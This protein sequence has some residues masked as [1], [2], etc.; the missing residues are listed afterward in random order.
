M[1]I[2]GAGIEGDS[3]RVCGCKI[4]LED[5]SERVQKRRGGSLLPCPFHADR[6]P[7]LAMGWGIVR[8]CGRSPR[9]Q[10][11]WQLPGDNI[12]LVTAV[13]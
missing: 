8:A 7:L 5:T 2:E 10:A 13:L 6:P 11:G 4:S 12:A 1:S 9:G 3:S